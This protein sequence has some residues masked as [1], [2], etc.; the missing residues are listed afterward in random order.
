MKALTSKLILNPDCLVVGAGISGLLTAALK[1]KEGKTVQLVEK[2][3]KA[4]GRFSPEQRQGFTLGASFS[5]GDAAWW[6]AI[7]DRLGFPSSLLPVHQGGALSHGPKGWLAPEDLPAWE[8]HFARPNTEY[9]SLGLFGIVQSLLQYCASYEGFSFATEAP[10]TGIEV[11]NGIGNLVRLGADSTST[12]KEI[13]WASDYK[14]LLE[15]LQGPGAPEPGPER[16]SWLKKFR[17]SQ[18][19]PAVVLEMAHKGK[20]SDFTE[21]L[22]LPFSHHEKEERRYLVGSFVS[23]R[24]PQLAPNGFSL[25]SWIFPLSENEWGDNHETMKKIRAAKRMLEKAFPQIEN[26][27][28]FERV[29]V[30]DSSIAPLAKKKGE[31]EPLLENMYLAADWAMPGG[32]TIES[33]VEGL[34]R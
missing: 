17:K 16:V 14:T 6:G 1:L 11:E 18:T 34:L 8:A 29:L 4:G 27:V 32:A 22:L 20:V 7:S 28:Y 21:T 13:Y 23:N 26:G 10:V 5:F 3:D 31:R 2:L 24:D 33:V 30:L 19:Q 25:S 12:P 15:I 9:P